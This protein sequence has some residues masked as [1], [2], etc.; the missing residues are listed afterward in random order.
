MNF[1]E[2]LLLYVDRIVEI[3]L[4][5]ENCITFEKLEI[6]KTEQTSVKQKSVKQ[7]YLKKVK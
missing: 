7:T 5:I 6:G 1:R 4:K 3:S 2:S